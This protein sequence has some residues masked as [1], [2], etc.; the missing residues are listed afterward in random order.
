[1]K[2]PTKILVLL[3]LSVFSVAIGIWYSNRL[4]QKSTAFSLSLATL[5][6][7]HDGQITSFEER[8][9]N[10]FVHLV[11]RFGDGHIHLLNHEDVTEQK[12]LARLKAKQQ[13]LERARAEQVIGGSGG[14]RR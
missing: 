7:I 8:G 3:S 2:L 6:Q 10:I 4:S 13:E 14:Q 1:M 5:E 11:D 12:A 9:S